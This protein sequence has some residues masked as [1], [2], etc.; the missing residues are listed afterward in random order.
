MKISG[1]VKLGGLVLPEQSPVNV[2]DVTIDYTV[3]F[4]IGELGEIIELTRTL[5]DVVADI[6]RKM[7][8]YEEEFTP[9]RRE[10]QPPAA[11]APVE[12]TM[13]DTEDMMSA[14]R[15]AELVIKAEK[16]TANV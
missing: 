4:G 7:K 12:P 3:E 2:S 14:I 10:A 5:P 13:K 16:L 9:L 15:E 11:K 8:S 1:V 6:M